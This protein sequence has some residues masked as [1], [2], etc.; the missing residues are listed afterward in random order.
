MLLIPELSLNND[1]LLRAY[2]FS[3]EEISSVIYVIQKSNIVFTKDPLPGDSKGR[4]GAQFLI[5]SSGVVKFE[6][7]L[8][9][10][11]SGWG[12]NTRV[13]LISNGSGKSYRCLRIDTPPNGCKTIFANDEKEAVVLCALIA[14]DENWLG[15]V[16]SPGRC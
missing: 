6:L 16:P 3:D 14:N 1:L 13:S 4:I 7:T 5:Y 2:S 8:N 11:F 15:G 12:K 9:I 10:K